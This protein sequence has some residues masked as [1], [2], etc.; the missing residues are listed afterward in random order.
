MFRALRTRPMKGC[1]TYN[2]P[3]ACCLPS[4]VVQ[5]AATVFFRFFLQIAQLFVSPI[6]GDGRP[7]FESY[8]GAYAV[9]IT[10][11]GKWQVCSDV[12]DTD[13]QHHFLRSPSARKKMHDLS[14]RGISIAIRG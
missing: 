5:Y 4:S 10:I 12:V 3:P 9:K 14:N 2:L 1:T 6:G 8:T 13:Y 11:G 7:V